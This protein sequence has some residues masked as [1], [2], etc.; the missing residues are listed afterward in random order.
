MEQVS[1][2]KDWYTKQEQYDRLVSTYKN[3]ETTKSI[4]KK[5]NKHDS[6]GNT[7]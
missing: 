5:V 4:Q 6:N 2:L 3:N 7:T 1:W